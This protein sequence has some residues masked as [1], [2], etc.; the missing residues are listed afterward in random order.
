MPRQAYTLLTS[1]DEFRHLRIKD[2]AVPPL[3]PKLCLL[4]PGEWYRILVESTHRR[5]QESSL[6]YGGQPD[7]SS[8]H[9]DGWIPNRARYCSLGQLSNSWS[10]HP[11]WDD[12]LTQVDCP[13]TDLDVEATTGVDADPGFI[14]N[15]NQITVSDV[16]R[17]TSSTLAS[18]SLPLSGHGWGLLVCWCPCGCGDSPSMSQRFH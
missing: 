8:L 10:I 16:P 3:F 6:D 7:K 13:I 12:G 11:A 9:F 18:P 2:S 17:C 4:P 15:R 14:V 5:S 1:R